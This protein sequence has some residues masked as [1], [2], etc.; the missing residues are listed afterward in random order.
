MQLVHIPPSVAS[1]HAPVRTIRASVEPGLQEDAQGAR[2]VAVA[3]WRVGSSRN[4]ERKQPRAELSQEKAAALQTGA[5]LVETAARRVYRDGTLHVAATEEPAALPGAVVER[6]W[7]ANDWLG[8]SHEY[9][10]STCRSTRPVGRASQRRT[11]LYPRTGTRSRSAA[12]PSG[13][14][15][16]DKCRRIARVCSRAALG[17]CISGCRGAFVD[18]CATKCLA[19]TT[20]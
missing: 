4:G 19:P 3:C 8:P 1:A 7:E 15:M 9:R 6:A 11:I 18:S 10:R 5:R 17:Y 20:A 14:C 13:R 2:R 16:D 12:C